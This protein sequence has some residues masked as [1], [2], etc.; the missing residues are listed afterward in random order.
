MLRVCENPT[1]TAWF[2]TPGDYLPVSEGFQWN[3]FELQSLEW[4]DNDSSVSEYWDKHL[5]V[6]M[7]VDG[8]Y[9]YYAVNTE[10]GNIV[11]GCEPEY[12]ISSVVAENFNDFIR[13]IINGEIIL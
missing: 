8:D 5:P 2:L 6:F 13:K 10:N 11:H 9:S 4:T 1:A 7:S 12:E 3:E